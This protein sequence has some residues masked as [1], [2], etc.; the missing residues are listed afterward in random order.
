M[1]KKKQMQH[2]VLCV[3]F[4]DFFFFSDRRLQF[5]WKTENMSAVIIIHFY[6]SS[7]TICKN[8]DEHDDD[9]DMFS[10]F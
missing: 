1:N 10:V 7:E 2:V 5:I 8:D 9:R 6:K 4:F 3:K